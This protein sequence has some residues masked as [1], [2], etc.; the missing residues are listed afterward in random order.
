[1][2]MA[3][4]LFWSCERSFWHWTTMLVGRCVM[5][6]AELVLLTCC[7]PAPLER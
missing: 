2:C 5:R 1:M 6:M 7:P 4:V 3:T